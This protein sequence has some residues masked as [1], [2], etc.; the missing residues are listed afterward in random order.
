[1]LAMGLH[2]ASICL[3]KAGQHML[4]M[5]LRRASICLPWG[6][7]GP[8][9]AYHGA[10]QEPTYSH[11]EHWKGAPAASSGCMGPAIIL[12]K[13]IKYSTLLMGPAI[14]FHRAIKC[15]T[16]LHGACNYTAQGQ[17]M[18]HIGTRGLCLRRRTCSIPQHVACNCNYVAQEQ[19]RMATGCPGPAIILRKAC[20]LPHGACPYI[21]HGCKG[22]AWLI[23]QRRRQL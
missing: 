5:G 17:Q 22:P 10:A 8:A 18:Q 12:H 2:R 13:A 1:M 20:V 11:M 6:C 7:T 15:T 16:L 3:H 19:T 23:L 21:V 4:A 14:I 9:Y